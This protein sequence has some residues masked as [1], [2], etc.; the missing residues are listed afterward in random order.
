MKP[1]RQPSVLPGF[2][3]TFGF[4]VLFLSGIVLLPLAALVLMT[5]SMPLSEFLRV[6]TDPRAIGSYRLS[7]G[8]SLLAASARNLAT[9]CVDG[10]TA[11]EN[12]PAMVER[13]L[14]LSTA[15]APRIG[16]DAAATIAKEA[17]NTGRTVRE[18]ARERSGLDEDELTRLLD[19][20]A[21]THPGRDAG[22]AGG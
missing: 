13:G 11:T 10:I 8:A 19:A 20:E 18:V 21:M 14:M 5:A 6:I 16:Y 12:G 3:L 22:P 4:T 15:L 17:Y 9:Q 7:F 2:G 1:L